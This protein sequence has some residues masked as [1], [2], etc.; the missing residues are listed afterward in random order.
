V[1]TSYT[2]VESVFSEELR[3]ALSIWVVSLTATTLKRQ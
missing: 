3:A 1:A 2:K